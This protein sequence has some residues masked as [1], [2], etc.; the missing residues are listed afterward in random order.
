MLNAME[1]ATQFIRSLQSLKPSFSYTRCFFHAVNQLYVPTRSQDIV[2]EEIC[3]KH[4]CNSAEAK[5]S[6][7][8]LDS[9][10]SQ[11]R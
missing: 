10:D 9:D 1:A 5:L 2:N 6:D 3:M 11:G 8:P 7:L 4:S